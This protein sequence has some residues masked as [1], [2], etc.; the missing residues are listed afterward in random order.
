MIYVCIGNEYWHVSTNSRMIYVEA[1]NVDSYLAS[2]Y[3]TRQLV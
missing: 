1:I 3:T 2:L